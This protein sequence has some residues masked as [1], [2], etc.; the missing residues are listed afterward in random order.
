MHFDRQRK[1]HAQR[2]K[3][4]NHIGCRV[5][6][7]MARLGGIASDEDAS[8]CLSFFIG[9]EVLLQDLS[10]SQQG[11]GAFVRLF[12]NVLSSGDLLGFISACSELR[13]GLISGGSWERNPIRGSK[14]RWVRGLVNAI[15]HAIPGNLC[16][17]PSVL[18]NRTI[19][20]LGWLK[21]LPV[22]IRATQESVVDYAR[23][24]ARIS[25]INFDENEYVPMLREIWEEW[26]G[27]FRLTEPFLPKHG[28]GSTADCG[29]IR[30]DKWRSLAVDGRARVLL[31]NSRLEWELDLPVTDQSRSAKV[32][33]VPK[34]AGK[35][36][37]ICMEPAWLQYLQQGVARQWVAYAHR[38]DHPLHRMVDI[39]SQENNRSLCA[40][41]WSDRLATID[42]SDAS[43][44]VSWRLI[45]AVCGRLPLGRYLY[46]CRSDYATIAG[47]KV[48][49]DKYAPMGSALCFPTECYVFAS[50]V[51][52]AH[53]IHYGQAS[54]GI[55]SGCSVYGDDIICPSE[56]Y[57]LVREILTSIGFVVNPEKSF[58]S[59]LYYESCGVEYL[60]GVKISTIRHPR[61]LLVCRQ[62][63]APETVGM[64]TDLAN[65]LLA[66]GCFSARRMLLKYFEQQTITVGNREWPFMA[67]VRFDDE[68]LVPIGDPSGERVWSR[69]YQ[70]SILVS[71]QVVCSTKRAPSDFLQWKSENVPR[72]RS[73]RLESRLRPGGNV[74][75]DPK[76]SKKAVV[77]LCR[78]GFQDL[79][80]GHDVEVVG[81]S[82]TGRPRFRVKRYV[83]GP[84]M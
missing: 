4:G 16:A 57:Q 41:A 9:V 83:A 37:T 77:F 23:T 20:F 76:F 75:V 50:V 44:S 26:F 49:I 60:S 64:V 53:R 34:Q 71:R 63:L 58:S 28:T 35:D 1:D 25:S 47:R 5:Q 84:E 42:L 8:F 55:Q 22:R 80:E 81:Q 46:A 14:Q 27:S 59:G 78:F 7:L 2:G 12:N 79:L 39:F 13:A 52:L 74:D 33:F 70:R 36:R 11:Y 54:R 45:K 3:P 65:S 21:R 48:E 51:E 30:H 6:A 66:F 15:D 24:E 68:H 73:E 29:R 43:D 72:S 31:R 10:C 82:R 62:G 40:W 67:L 18:F 61:K 38:P 19:T 69:D 56:L 17:H 32:V